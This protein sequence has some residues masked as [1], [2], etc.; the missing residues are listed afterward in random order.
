MMWTILLAAVYPVLF[1]GGEPAGLVKVPPPGVRYRMNMAMATS[2][3]WVDSNIWRYRRDPETKYFCDVRGK[4]VQLAAAEA[5]SQGVGVSL[6]TTPEQKQDYDAILEFLKS[7]PQGP[8]K[9]WADVRIAS[10]DGSAQAGEALN[11]LARRNIFYTTQPGARGSAL[12][13]D[14]KITNAYEYM[15]DVR[16]KIGD[17]KRVLRIFGSEL[18]IATLT[19]AG[20]RVRLQLVNYGNRPVET[21]RI[22]IQGHYTEKN[23]HARVFKVAE[24]HLA[25]FAHE[26]NYTEFTL[27][28]LPLYAVLDFD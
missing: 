9:P 12:R 8:A 2:S 7:I 23:I 5:F 11:L 15:Q 22:R 24:P 13:L 21:L 3:P 18:T 6:Q 19:R 17:D 27:E 4:S 25:E 10:D 14:S 1:P 16:E 28:E 26:G 20:K